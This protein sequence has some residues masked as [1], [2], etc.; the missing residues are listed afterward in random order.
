MIFLLLSIT[1]NVINAVILKR[2]EAARHDRLV[3]MAAN[4]LVAG[5]LALVVWVS[6]GAEPFSVNTLVLGLVGG[7]FYSTALLMWMGA[8]QLAGIGTSTAAL[9]MGVAWPVVLSFLI[10]AEVP[11][12]FQTLGIALSLVAIVMVSVAGSAGGGGPRNTTVLWLAGTWMLAGGCYVTLKVFTEISPATDKEALLALIFCSAGVMS[13][14]AVA[15]MRRRPTRRNMINGGVFGAL[16]MTSS[17]LLL[18]GL[19]TVP[20]ILAFPILNTGILFFAGLLGVLVWRERPGLWGVLALP[21][22]AGAIAL[23]SL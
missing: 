16:N 22:S 21:V 18:M 12:G 8:I 15:V 19:Q 13:W 10:F 7:F 2:G 6:Q 9:R 14:L 23:M 11:T 17:A 4:Y 3:V 1:T 5:A 20:G